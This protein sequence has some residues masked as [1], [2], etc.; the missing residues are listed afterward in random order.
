M[1]GVAE[2]GGMVL[3]EGCGLRWNKMGGSLV[4]GGR[5]LEEDEDRDGGMTSIADGSWE[6]AGVV[7]RVII[8]GLYKAITGQ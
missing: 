4:V 2:R 6:G 7:A 3:V 8:V 5:V 1:A